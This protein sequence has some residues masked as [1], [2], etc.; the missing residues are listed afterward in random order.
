MLLLRFDQY[1]TTNTARRRRRLRRSR[2]GFLV[3]TWR[4]HA[5]RVPFILF[6]KGAL[7]CYSG[8][9]VYIICWVI[10]SRLLLDW[11]F[12][13]PPNNRENKGDACERAG[14]FSSRFHLLT[15]FSCSSLIQSSRLP[16]FRLIRWRRVP[17]LLE[18]NIKLLL[19]DS[20]M[21]NDVWRPSFALNKL[22]RK[23]W[24]KKETTHFYFLPTCR[25]HFFQSDVTVLYKIQ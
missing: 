2:S 20:S 7:C 11:I 19:R 24:E 17:L 3:L 18:N 13:T 5:Q 25:F 4:L 9:A 21:A 14:R 16:R 23:E 10:L 6:L 22:A 1:R 15:M 8:C 12:A